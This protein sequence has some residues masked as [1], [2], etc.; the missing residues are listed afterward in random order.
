MLIILLITAKIVTLSFLK[1]TYRGKIL[2]YL[3]V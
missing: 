1:F 3:G 2:F